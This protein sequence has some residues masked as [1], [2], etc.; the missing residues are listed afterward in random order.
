[1]SERACDC[2]VSTGQF[3]FFS[4][5]RHSSRVE[6]YILRDEFVD[7]AYGNRGNFRV[8]AVPIVSFVI[9]VVLGITVPSLGGYI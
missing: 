9:V 4:C 6:N 8:F 5:S 2:C 7:F 3:F 1:M